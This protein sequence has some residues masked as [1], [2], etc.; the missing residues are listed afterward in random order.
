MKKVVIV[1]LGNVG[2]AYLSTLIT[3]DNLV[4]EIV[5]IDTNKNKLEGELLDIEDSL[6][7]INSNIDIYI[8][9]YKD[10]KDA[11]ILVITAGK[12]QDIGETR[13]DLL[14]V[15]KTIVKGITEEA[16]LNGFKGIFIVSTN[17]VDIMSYLVFKT[18]NMPSN[19]VIGSGTILDTSR[20]KNILKD[21]TNIN[22]N[23]ISVNVIG[24]HGDN[25]VVLWSK[26]NISSIPLDNLF[27][28]EEKSNMEEMVKNRA[29]NIIN[30]K[31]YTSEGIALSLLNITKAILNNENKVL[32]VSTYM[33][34][35][36]IGMPSI[37][38]IN[39]VKGVVNIEFTSSEKEKMRT[40]INRIKSVI[41]DM[42]V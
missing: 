10:T 23:D 35:I 33:N 19:R 28:I 6:S 21:K 8:G 3:E 31:G 41:D 7:V 4:N 32:N 27:S 36:Y 40:S 38:N 13:L 34:G 9:D 25:I 18:S 24:E 20:L 5:L 26:G 39:G 12:N 15:N 17:P 1:G 14:D 16:I 30:K 42:E 22:L 37:I 2:T 11:D 29:T